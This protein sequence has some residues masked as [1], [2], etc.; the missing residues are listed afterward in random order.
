M[1]E[2]TPLRRVRRPSDPGAILRAHYMEPRGVSVSDLAEAVGVSRKHMSQVVN[3][4]KRIEAALAVRLARVLDT[5]PTL[6]MNLQ[7]AVDTFDASA[8][9]ADWT[10]DRTFEAPV[11]A[12]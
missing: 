7:A 11:A 8:E 9:L 6:W 4:H 12:E 1:S 2:N 10:P 3:G 5:T